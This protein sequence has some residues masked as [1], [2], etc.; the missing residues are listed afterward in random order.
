MKCVAIWALCLGT[1]TL[2]GC[3]HNLRRSVHE[4]GAKEALVAAIRAFPEAHYGALT[5]FEVRVL[6]PSESTLGRKDE[7]WP[8][9]FKDVGPNAQVGSSILLNV[10]R[11]TGAVTV[12]GGM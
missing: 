3:S 11:R 6:E 12:W 2:S 7:R 9:F 4:V 5:N 10:D 1:A 8:V